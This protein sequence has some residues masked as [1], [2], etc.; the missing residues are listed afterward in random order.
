MDEEYKRHKRFKTPIWLIIVF[1]LVYLLV[2]AIL[3][4]KGFGAVAILG[5][6][7]LVY[8]YFAIKARRIDT[9]QDFSKIGDYF[10]ELEEERYEEEMMRQEALRRQ[11]MRKEQQRKKAQ[12]NIKVR[13]ATYKSKEN[14]VEDF[15]ENDEDVIRFGEE[16]PKTESVEVPKAEPTEVDK[17]EF[18]KVSTETISKQEDF[19]KKEEIK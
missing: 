13:K 10:Y 17:K 7:V 16:T 1:I 18:E 9:A 14:P 19:T 6:M 5:L 15:D 4:S 12:E 2:S 3:F 11:R 8:Q